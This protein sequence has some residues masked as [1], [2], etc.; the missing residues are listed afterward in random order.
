MILL[1]GY[2]GFA[3]LLLGWLVGEEVYFIFSDQWDFHVQC[4]A[5]TCPENICPQNE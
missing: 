5:L 2:W 3:L 1:K 4:T